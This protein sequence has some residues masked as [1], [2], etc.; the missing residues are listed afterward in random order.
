[1][2]VLYVED[3]DNL[4]FAVE[5]ML[6]QAGHICDRARTGAGAVKLG[7]EHQYDVI[8]LDVMLPDIDGYEVLRQLQ[9]VGVETPVLIQSGLVERDRSMD[10]LGFGVDDYLIK[11]FNRDEL[12]SQV[13]KAAAR[14][15]RATP[16]ET[17]DS[18]PDV[19]AIGPPPADSSAPEPQVIHLPAA[20]PPAPE[21]PV[22]EPPAPD[23]PAP[24]PLDLEPPAPE[25]PVTDR[26]VPDLP[27]PEPPEPDL[28]LA[29]QPIKGEM[30][31]PAPEADV[32][33]ADT[34]PP[35]ASAVSD[36]SGS[37]AAAPPAPDAPAADGPPL[38]SACPELPARI[39]GSD[40]EL[41]IDC[42]IV[43]LSSGGAVLDVYDET[44]D[45][46]DVFMLAVVG[47]KSYRCESCW[48]HAGKIGVK[49]A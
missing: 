33:A 14:G 30:E 11:P 35:P 47:D 17:I 45:C 2:R 38:P 46:P 37:P 7:Q 4:A 43:S 18:L 42:T 8:L 22:T 34:S 21:P 24:E 28:P 26:P 27:E 12:I 20:E 48:R 1:M 10:G 15:G 5:K 13:E 19:L 40:S 3:D 6:S 32:P 23:L 31:I 29:E 44:V 36:V 9:E 39:V 25:P 49:F 16:A 41:P